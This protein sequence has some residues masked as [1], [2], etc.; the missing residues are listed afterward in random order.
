MTGGEKETAVGI[1]SNR[2]WRRQQIEAKFSA[3]IRLFFQI[4]FHRS[5]PNIP[6]LSEDNGK[7]QK[8]TCQHHQL[9]SPLFQQLRL[10]DDD[11]DDNDDNDD[12]NNNDDDDNGCTN[13][14]LLSSSPTPISRRLRPNGENQKKKTKRKKQQ[15]KTEKQFAIN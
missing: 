1:L 9:F 10:E 7:Q 5:P 4:A 3:T 2:K 6:F 14:P 8:M 13:R 11:N 12:D 15:I